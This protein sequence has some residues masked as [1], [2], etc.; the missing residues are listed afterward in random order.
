MDIDSDPFPVFVIFIHVSN[1]SGTFGFV[2]CVRE[3]AFCCI[4]VSQGDVM[5]SC[6]PFVE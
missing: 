6:M 1:L 3:D 5:D 4:N 2:C